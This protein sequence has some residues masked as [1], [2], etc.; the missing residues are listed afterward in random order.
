[1]L[2]YN[3]IEDIFSQ[4][5]TPEKSYW[6]GF[7]YADG[8]ITSQGYVLSIALKESDKQHLLNFESFLN[9]SE[10]ILKYNK[11]TNSWRF[12]IS[13]KKIYDD[14]VKIGFTSSKSYDNTLNVWNNIPEEYKKDFILGLWDGDGSI[15]ITPSQNRQVASLISNN[16][17]LIKVIA[18]YINFYLGQN[19]C[20][21]KTRTEGDPYPR[22][23]IYSNKAK[24]F[25]DWLYKNINY[26]VLQRKYN[27]YKNFK[28]RDKAHFGFNNNKTKG[29]ICLDS[30]KGYMTA[31]ECCIEEF[32]I[33]NPGAI[34]CIRQ[35]CRGERKQ[36]R[37]KHF[38]YMT[39]E[40]RQEFKNGRSY[41]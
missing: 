29:I 22:I 38:R 40:E 20:S 2:K 8:S 11:K 32:G 18:E 3:F 16:D 37:N 6:I 25:G 33:D 10:D 28:I 12:A 13:R 1:M 7:L 9:I 27:T 15:S 34:N 35:V 21:I 26:P 41:F 23:R 17:E 36:T 5:N 19:F 39:K 14:L 24:I 30:K 4:I 31:K